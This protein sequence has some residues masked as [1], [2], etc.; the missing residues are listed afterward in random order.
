MGYCLEKVGCLLGTGQ[1]VFLGGGRRGALCLVGWLS[2]SLQACHLL[3]S[4]STLSAVQGC[5]GGIHAACAAPPGPVRYAGQQRGGASH[6]AT[7]AP[8]LPQ[9]GIHRCAGTLP[10]PRPTPN[11][12]TPLAHHTLPC[13]CSNMSRYLPWMASYNTAPHLHVAK[14]TTPSPP[15][16]SPLQT[17]AMRALPRSGASPRYASST[18][19]LALSQ[20]PGCSTSRG[21]RRW[22]RST[23][24]GRG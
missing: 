16:T 7:A 19:T 24:S 2:H 23:C 6:S 11:A 18:S 3:S 9:Y 13:A 14:V 22:K 21:C 20:T 4:S 17:W 10:H 1:H 8:H 15:P 12:L 5:G